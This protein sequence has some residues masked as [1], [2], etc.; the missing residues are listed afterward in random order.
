M[1]ASLAILQVTPT[2]EPPSEMLDALATYSHQLTVSMAVH[3]LW[4]A[5]AKAHKSMEAELPFTMEWIT[6]MLSMKMILERLLKMAGKRWICLE[7]WKW[8]EIFFFI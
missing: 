5:D 1:F 6:P 2:L 4:R 8:P 3:R 7:I